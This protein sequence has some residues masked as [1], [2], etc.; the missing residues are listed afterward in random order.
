MYDLKTGVGE[1][2]RLNLQSLPVPVSHR[3]QKRVLKM[4]TVLKVRHASADAQDTGV[5]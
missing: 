4:C 3:K 5:R 1:F 2:L